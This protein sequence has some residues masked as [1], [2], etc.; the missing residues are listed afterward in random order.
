MSFPTPPS[1]LLALGTFA[2]LAGCAAVPAASSAAPDEALVLP[3]ASAERLDLVGAR[4]EPATHDGRAGLRVE[5]LAGSP[6]GKAT[7]AIVRDVRLEDGEIELEVAGSPR[8]G[9]PA[10]VRG[11]IGIAFHVSDD[12]ARYENVYLRPSNGRAE[13]QLRRNHAVQ[14]QSVPDFGWYRLREESPGQ[15]ESYADLQVGTWTRMR[16]RIQGTRAELYI[17]GAAQ[18]CLIVRDLKLGATGGR[19][20]LWA[21]PTTEAYFRDLRL[22]PISRP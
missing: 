9:S 10:D 14:Y 8:P 18:P 12:G 20:A 6:S 5:P 19:V 1:A 4:A 3:L 11:F 22:R 2:V 21:D 16:L 13:E 17:D 15:Y 7:L